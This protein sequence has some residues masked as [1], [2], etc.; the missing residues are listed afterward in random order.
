[1][2]ATDGARGT[3]A[4]PRVA[5][6]GAGPT[7][8][9]AAYRLAQLGYAEFAVY[10]RNDWVGGVAAS[11]RDVAEFPWDVGGHVQF[12]H[13]EDFDLAMD[14]TMGGDCLWHA[15]IMGVDSRSFPPISVSTQHAPAA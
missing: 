2:G 14:A 6:G 3:M 15:R 5:N 8:L 13:Y 4:L 9:G 7:S 11:V 1:M 10:E 12:S